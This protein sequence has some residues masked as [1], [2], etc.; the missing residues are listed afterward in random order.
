MTTPNDQV[1]AEFVAA[2]SRAFTQQFDRFIADRGL[3]WD[4]KSW[5]EQDKADFKAQSDVLVEEWKNRA[6]QL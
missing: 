1:A 4:D 6:D 2:R 3:D 5:S